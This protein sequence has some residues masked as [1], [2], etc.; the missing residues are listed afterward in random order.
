MK[1]SR[2]QSLQLLAST[3]MVNGPL[4]L[5][6]LFKNSVYKEPN[7]ILCGIILFY[8][9]TLSIFRTTKCVQD[10]P[11]LGPDSVKR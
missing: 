2:R 5:K 11:I 6:I 7:K 3:P 4:D 1:I 8:K 9:T 10:H